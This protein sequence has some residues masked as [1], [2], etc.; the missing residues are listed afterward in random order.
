MVN[1]VLDLLLDE[2]TLGKGDAELLDVDGVVS[3]EPDVVL[4]GLGEAEVIL[5]F[6]ED[7]LEGV[8]ESPV[9]RALLGGGTGL[10]AFCG[11]MC[12]LL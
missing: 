8:D 9:G 2:G 4:D 7:V 10:K 11:G 12:A 5:T 6:A 1:Q 3:A